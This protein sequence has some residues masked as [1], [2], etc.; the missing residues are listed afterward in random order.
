MVDGLTK[1]SV[2]VVMTLVGATRMYSTQACRERG[3]TGGG[4]GG[5]ER[6]RGG[7]EGR[8]WERVRGRGV[9]G[10]GKRGVRGG[11]ERGG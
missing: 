2:A 1:Q 4:G 11:G 7:G 10:E 3:R 6:A 9:R 8:G 5:L